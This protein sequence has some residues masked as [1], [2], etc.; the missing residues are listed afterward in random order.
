MH[1]GFLYGVGM[2]GCM[3]V[4]GLINLMSQA[5]RIDLY[6]AMSI[7]GYSLLPLVFLALI[8]VFV[9]LRWVTL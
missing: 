7:L 1:F 5:K 2:L 6:R 8:A 3:G 9:S 4:Y